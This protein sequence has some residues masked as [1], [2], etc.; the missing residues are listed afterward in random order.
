MGISNISPNFFGKQT[1]TKADE[2]DIKKWNELVENKKKYITIF[3]EQIENPDFTPKENALLRVSILK[4]RARMDNLKDKSNNSSKLIK[5]TELEELINKAKKIVFKFLKSRTNDE[6]KIQKYI[7]TGMS[8]AEKYLKH[9]IK[10]KVEIERL[11][12]GIPINHSHSFKLDQLINRFKEKVSKS[13][14]AVEL[15]KKE[16]ADLTTKFSKN[17]KVFVKKSKNPVKEEERLR[18]LLNKLKETA[19]I[20]LAEGEKYDIIN[21][22]AN[23]KLSPKESAFLAPFAINFDA[24][25]KKLNQKGFLDELADEMVNALEKDF[26]WFFPNEFIGTSR[27]INEKYT[28]FKDK[29]KDKIKIILN[30]TYT[31]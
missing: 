29:I 17:I 31:L 11:I 23:E 24:I 2:V 30:E 18:N 6:D 10:N 28:E 22:F 25:D 7:T 21:S 27:T 14:R 4:I 3:E 19:T 8:E 20:K 15:L 12:P 5:E 1:G 26:F 13:K 9:P 16:K